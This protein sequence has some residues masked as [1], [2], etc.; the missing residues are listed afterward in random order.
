MT[1]PRSRR[2]PSDAA[3]RRYQPPRQRKARV[4]PQG[5]EQA[6]GREPTP[7]PQPLQTDPGREHSASPAPELDWIT[8]SRE[9]WFR[10]IEERFRNALVADMVASVLGARA[11]RTVEDASAI[12]N[13]YLAR[14]RE[15]ART[16]AAA[17]IAS[18]DWTTYANLLPTFLDVLAPCRMPPRGG[19]PPQ[20]PGPLIQAALRRYDEILLALQSGRH[21]PDLIREYAPDCPK[22]RAAVLVGLSNYHIAAE[23]AVWGT[24]I[25][26][27]TLIHRYAPT[28]KTGRLSAIA[29]ELG[30]WSRTGKSRRSWRFRDRPSEIVAEPIQ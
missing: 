8:V 29:N 7:T 23:L 26:P 6:L 24:R 20:T 5:P 28:Q 17:A 12:A 13:E 9:D 4:T 2:R 30:M 3:P 22:D 1:G 21:A 15:P 27:T 25:K 18:G 11:G 16:A 10:L 14:I 19:R